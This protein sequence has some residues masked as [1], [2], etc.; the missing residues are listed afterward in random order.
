[1]KTGAPGGMKTFDS[2]G[3]KTPVPEGMKTRA[4]RDMCTRIFY[5]IKWLCHAASLDAFCISRQDAATLAALA[6]SRCLTWR[7]LAPRSAI[8]RRL[9]DLVGKA[10]ACN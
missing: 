7:S 3:M 1:M 5:H 4:P 10:P 8:D 9:R 2:N 6:L